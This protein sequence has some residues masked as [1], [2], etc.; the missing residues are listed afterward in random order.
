M[1][2][3][4][5]TP[6]AFPAVILTDT[7]LEVI[8]SQLGVT[9]QQVRE[10]MVLSPGENPFAGASL[11]AQPFLWTEP[12][13]SEIH[14][15][16]PCCVPGNL[17]STRYIIGQQQFRHDHK[18]DTAGILRT[19]R[20][21]LLRRTPLTAS[22]LSSASFYLYDHALWRLRY[23]YNIDIARDQITHLI[24][25]VDGTSPLV[26][27]RTIIRI[28]PAGCSLPEFPKHLTLVRFP[29]AG[30]NKDQLDDTAY[31][32]CGHAEG[33]AQQA[34]RQLRNAVCDLSDLREHALD[35]N[36]TLR[37]LHEQ[38]DELAVA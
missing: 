24:S 23:A 9:E 29:L 32:E 5:A 13:A 27:E 26:D 22:T 8:T 38:L 15:W 4:T 25:L 6:P 20:N 33:V 3:M 2:F 36:G 14:S 21:R 11:D 12:Q 28:V 30:S 37:V 1:A 31:R 17:Q 35:S 34:P 18:P 19:V 7:D 16:H 10:A